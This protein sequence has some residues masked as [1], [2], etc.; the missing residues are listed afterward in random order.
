[1]SIMLSDLNGS[2]VIDAKNSLKLPNSVY[3]IE[4][5]LLREKKRIF[6]I[7]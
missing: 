2:R 3:I 4:P 1:M 5:N 7:Y 6:I